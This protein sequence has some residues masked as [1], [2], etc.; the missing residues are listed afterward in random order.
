[1]KDSTCRIESCPNPDYICGYC[2]T[3]YQALSYEERFW[4][5]VKVVDSACWEWQTGLTTQGYGHFRHP[6]GQTAHRYSYQLAYGDLLSSDCVLHKC[7]NRPCVNPEHLF[8]GSRM[9]NN[10]DMSQ[11][12]RNA[13]RKLEP[14]EVREIRS[15]YAKGV[16]QKVIAEK[17]GIIQPTVSQIVRRVT[18]QHL[19]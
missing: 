4:A 10:R 3:H 13:S 18:W 17:Y 1:M 15:L 8:K 6:L 7:D 14:D 19:D 16:M 11:K 12:L 5:Q 9:D 2:K